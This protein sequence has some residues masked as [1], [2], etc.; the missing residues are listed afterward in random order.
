MQFVLSLWLYVTDP[1]SL[2]Q[3]IRNT[4]LMFLFA[5]WLKG[6]V[7]QNNDLSVRKKRTISCLKQRIWF[8]TISSLPPPKYCNN[9]LSSSRFLFSRTIQLLIHMLISMFILLSDLNRGPPPHLSGT[10]PG[11]RKVFYKIKNKLF[12]PQVAFILQRRYVCIVLLGYSY[13]TVDYPLDL[14]LAHWNS[15]TPSEP[16]DRGPDI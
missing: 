7:E 9:P 8:H 11:H 3:I 2:Y 1:N 10:V 15:C 6:F 4:G 16:P 13:G 14:K 5:K 12:P